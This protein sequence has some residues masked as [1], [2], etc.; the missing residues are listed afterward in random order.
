MKTMWC[1]Y[2]R[3]LAAYFKAPVAYIVLAVFVGFAGLLFFNAS[4]FTTGVASMRGLFQFALPLLL[5]IFAPAMTMRLLAEERGSGTIELLLTMPVRDRE[6]VLGKFAA[7]VTLLVAA[8]LATVPFAFVVS[9]LGELDW[10]ATFGGYVGALLLGTVYLSLGL[11]G[12]ALARDQVVAFIIGVALCLAVF[13]A[14]WFLEP[15]QLGGLVGWLS[16]EIHYQNMV[17][18][19]VE[20]R[21]LVYFAS[22][23]GI[24]VVLSI[25]ALEA[26]K[27]G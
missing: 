23:I 6:V 25:Q 5:V 15:T 19:F 7:A 20:L 9:A 3:E 22:A 2:K 13:A 27:W 10:G 24:P 16:P 18:G 11:I 26:R 12:S 17:R 8:L 14:M 1:I 21:G 4:F